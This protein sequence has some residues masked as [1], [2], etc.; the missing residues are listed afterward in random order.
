[1]AGFFIYQFKSLKTRLTVFLL[2]PV[3]LL[4]ISGGVLNYFFSRNLIIKQWNESTVLKLARAAYSIERRLT[5][6][7]NILNALFTEKSVYKGTGRDLVALFKEFSGVKNAVFTA[8]SSSA[9]QGGVRGAG[10]HR[11]Q[12]TKIFKSGI[13]HLFK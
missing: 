12:I 2:L 5:G 9:T 10:F 11:C 6:P 3:L 4:L 8:D 1:M 7:L 13:Q